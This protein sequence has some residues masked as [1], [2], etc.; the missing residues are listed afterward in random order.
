MK[1]RR[2]RSDRYSPAV[3]INGSSLLENDFQFIHI[4]LANF[5]RMSVRKELYKLGDPCKTDAEC[6]YTKDSKCVKNGLCKA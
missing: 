1:C 3:G 4:R 5:S 6:T 2:G